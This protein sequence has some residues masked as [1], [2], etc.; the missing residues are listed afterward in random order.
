MWTNS[1]NTESKVDES[2]RHHLSEVSRSSN[3]TKFILHFLSVSQSDEGSYGCDITWSD[4]KSKGNRMHVNVTAAVPYQRTVLHRVLVCAGASLCLPIILGLARCL[5]SE[6]KPQPLPR[7]LSS[8]ADVHI[9]L[10]ERVPQPPPRCP[11]PQKHRKVPCKAATKSQQKTE[12]VYADISQSALRQPAD[13]REP[14]HST[15]YSD[16]RFS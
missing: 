2:E 7:R 9:D 13:V 11:V 12:V 4:G 10:L 14:A 8:E 1:E 15:V 16:V 6:V 3:E 5:S